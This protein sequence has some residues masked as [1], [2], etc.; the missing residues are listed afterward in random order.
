MSEAR[1]DGSKGKSLTARIDRLILPPD[2][3]PQRSSDALTWA[4]AVFE[5]IALVAVVICFVLSLLQF[6]VALF[7]DWS[8]QFVV[9]LLILVAVEGFFYS[10]RLTH[11]IFRPKEWLVLLAPPIVL[12]RFLP[13]LGL[14]GSGD[15]LDVI[16]WLSNPGLV[17]TA[18]Y[19]VELLLILLV[20]GVV[21]GCT[22]LLNGVRVQPGEII[23]ETNLRKRQ[24]LEDNWRAVDHSAPLRLLGELFAY[25]CLIL[26]F[27]SGL[28]SL[29]TDQFASIEAIGQII[30]FARPSVHLVLINVVG[31]V[32]IGLLLLGEAQY[33]RQRTLWR[34][35][36]LTVPLSVSA[37]WGL[38]L[39]GLV[40][41]AVA[42][43]FVLPTS[44][45]MTLGEVVSTI[46]FA[47]AQLALFILGLFVFVIAVIGS[48][49]GVNAK[50]DAAAQ[51]A[52]PPQLHPVA[53]PPV[54]GSLLDT[55]QS[56]VFW[57]VVLAIVGYSFYVIWR[58][59]PAWA[60]RIPLRQ[61]LS[62]RWSFFRSLFKLIRRVGMDVGRAVM[63]AIPRIL[64]STPTHGPRTP[65]F[66]SLTRLSPRELVEYYYLSVCERAARLGYPRPADVTPDEYLPRLRE[67]LP[68]VDPEIEA[69][70]AA[71][72][73]AR[74]GPRPTSLDRAKQLRGGWEALKKKLRSAR[75]KRTPT[76]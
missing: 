34:I 64:R 50:P 53:P 4:E 32:V 62:A 9:P 37:N 5:P 35:D 19:V 10:R 51:A 56:I 8:T 14:V 24:F 7:P 73:E 60:I 75:L 25:G 36:R 54:G 29:G 26:V 33:V 28:A 22:Q 61:W 58:R 2:F 46:L 74:Y 42:I 63:L 12:M 39:A 57:L 17:L 21:V 13:N 48:L 30:G 69:L 55:I 66:L 70:T 52:R 18:S 68:M 15:S 3:A 59:R 31:F 44:Y 65:S 27:L 6:G 45:A 67:H 20:W 38:G 76:I 71:F 11:T 49:L 16:S 1:S 23:Q 41:V 40:G 47:V 72:L 43:A